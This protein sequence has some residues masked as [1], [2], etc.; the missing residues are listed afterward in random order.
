MRIR[1]RYKRSSYQDYLNQYNADV[2]RIRA[3]YDSE[4][5]QRDFNYQNYLN[6]LD[7]DYRQSEF[8]WRKDIDV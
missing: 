4:I 8:D 1:R 3:A 7:S 6:K 5:G 2:D